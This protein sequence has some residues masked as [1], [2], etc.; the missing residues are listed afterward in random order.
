MSVMGRMGLAGGTEQTP[1]LH[2]QACII[3]P[4]AMW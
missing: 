3:R 2:G 4:P 1:D